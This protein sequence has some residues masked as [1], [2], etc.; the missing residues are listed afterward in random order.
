MYA[1]FSVMAILQ[2]FSL[3]FSVIVCLFMIFLILIQSGKGGSVGIFGGTGSNTAFGA[4]TMDVVTKLTWWLAAAFFTFSILAAVAF[5]DGGPP[6]TEKDTPANLQSNEPTSI[7]QKQRNE[8][9]TNEKQTKEKKGTSKL[10][11]QLKGEVK[12]KTKK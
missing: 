9:Q 11:T 6:S 12:D 2:T 8:K 3:F 7:P 5:A 4:S 1:I 10:N